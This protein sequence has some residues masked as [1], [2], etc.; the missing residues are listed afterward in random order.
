M[1]KYSL[2][3][4]MFHEFLLIFI[5]KLGVNPMICPSLVSIPIIAFVIYVIS[6]LIIHI[7]SAIPMFR[8]FMM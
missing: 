1:S 2:A 3:I 4:Y 8:K 5:Q 6:F 7:M